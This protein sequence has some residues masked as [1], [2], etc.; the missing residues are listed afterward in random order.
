MNKRRI[1][2]MEAILACII[3]RPRNIWHFGHIQ[4]H[5][6]GSRWSINQF[7]KITDVTNF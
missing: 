5:L 4:D 6:P 3:K 1:A 7:W 2:F